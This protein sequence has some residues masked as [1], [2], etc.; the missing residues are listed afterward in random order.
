MFLHAHPDKGKTAQE[1]LDM[2]K[3]YKPGDNVI[4]PVDLGQVSDEDDEDDQQ[5]LAQARELS[6]DD[7]GLGTRSTQRP[8]QTH[9]RPINRHAE[10]PRSSQTDGLSHQSSIRSLLS[11]SDVDLGDMEDE[12]MRHIIDHGLL[13]GMDL[14]NLTPDQEDAIT[15]SI[16]QAYRSRRRQD[17]RDRDRIRD[18]DRDREP[19]AAH[20]SP[21]TST[22]RH[23][24]RSSTHR[25]SP[26]TPTHRRTTSTT[27]TRNPHLLPSAQTHPSSARRRAA[28]AN[29][30]PRLNT[31]SDRHQ[32]LNPDSSSRPSNHSSPALPLPTR[33]EPSSGIPSPSITCSTCEKPNIQHSLHYNCDKCLEG[34]FNLCLECYHAGKGCLNWY[35]FGRTA[36]VRY[37]PQAAPGSEHVHLDPPHVLS[38]RKHVQST[39]ILEQGLF[40]DGCQ[41]FANACYWHCNTCNNGAWGFCNACVQQGK[42]CT[43]PLAS[44]AHV[45]QAPSSSHR[46]SPSDLY[47]PPLTSVTSAFHFAVP[48]SATSILP[49]VPNPSS[50]TSVTLSSY[51]DICH[52][53]IPLSHSRFHCNTCNKGN[54]DICTS[55]YHS[56]CNTGK[57][58]RDNGPSGWRR[59]LKSHR[60]TVIGHED[61]EGGSRRLIVRDLVGGWAL[62]ED[63]P[64]QSTTSTTTTNQWRWKENDGTSVAVS[65]ASTHPSKHPSSSQHFPPDGGIGFR[66][67][68]LWSYIPGIEATDELS[69]PK[70]AIISE[71]EDINGD[72]YWGVYCGRKG[73][74]PGNYVRVV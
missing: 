49:H 70:H 28:S 50:Y 52:Y 32:R 68:A 60:M 21:A 43:H 65:S 31:A 33:E 38:A 22:H 3:T 8:R 26:S 61:R 44:V 71:V 55:C 20:H 48:S 5:M 2:D 17:R 14:N 57:I 37:R 73:L 6:L 7:V 53:S 67:Q 72:W 27:T 62:K 42:H 10:S 74:F 39:A 24:P 15:D 41:A 64:T 69:F 36:F 12:I 29:L 47:P 51:C 19:S 9:T 13:D 56:L 18:R 66:A 11:Q 1:K 45:A 35:G 40:C 46:H 58:S 23:S 4:P 59:C 34:S 63:L 54:Y 25:H 30:T 16:A